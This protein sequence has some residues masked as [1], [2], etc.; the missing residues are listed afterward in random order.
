[1]S[2]NLIPIDELPVELSYEDAVEAVYGDDLDWIEN[3]LRQRLSVRVE[4]DKQL[5]LYFYRAL[6]S[7]L[8]RTVLTSCFC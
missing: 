4:C 3:K 2:G 1:M 6:R 7:R 5:T 8:K